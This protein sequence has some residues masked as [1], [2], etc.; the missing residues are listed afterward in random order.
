MAHIINTSLPTPK[1][2]NQKNAQKTYLHF[3]DKQYMNLRTQ[4]NVTCIVTHQKLYRF[5]TCDT[6]QRYS[7][8][9]ATAITF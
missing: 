3:S 6:L 8:V 1:L 9:F 5:M 2:L 4:K 7:S